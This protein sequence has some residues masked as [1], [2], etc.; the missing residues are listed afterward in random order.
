VTAFDK[1]RHPKKKA[2]LSAFSNC[3]SV[4][5][6]A[7]AARIDRT[8]HYVWMESPE[9]KAAFDI[10]IERATRHLEDIAAK[11][12]VEGS[13][14][15]L[16]FL[17]KCRNRPVFGDRASFEHTGKDGKD[18]FA[19]AALENWVKNGENTDQA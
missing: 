14:T 11:R 2:F 8:L 12:A 18:L 15:L 7:E 10:A 13:D 19:A 9:Y 6:A 3:G 17:L 1:V 16:I 5:Q 4:T